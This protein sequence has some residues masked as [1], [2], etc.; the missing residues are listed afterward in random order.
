[1]FDSQ[2]T[3]LKA[4]PSIMPYDEIRHR[5]HHPPQHPVMDDLKLLDYGIQNQRTLQ[6]VLAASLLHRQLGELIST[7]VLP[8]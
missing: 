6:A 8:N 7:K 1:M 3:P 5:T 2:K 4:I